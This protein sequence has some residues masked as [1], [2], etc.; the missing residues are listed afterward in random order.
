MTQ[1]QHWFERLGGVNDDERH[2]MA[3]AKEIFGQRGW[4]TARLQMP[5]CWRRSRTTPDGRQRVSR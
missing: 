5:A 2:R 1:L 4:D 3:L